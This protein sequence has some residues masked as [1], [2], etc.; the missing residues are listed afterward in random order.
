MW[1]GCTCFGL[2]HHLTVVKGGS[3]EPACSLLARSFGAAEIIVE[4]RDLQQDTCVAARL[5]FNIG[6]MPSG[7]A[8]EAQRMAIRV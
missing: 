2:Q 5:D 1:V 4:A 3:I 7:A 8:L 6:S